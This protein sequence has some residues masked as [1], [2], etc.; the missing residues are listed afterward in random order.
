MP[1]TAWRMAATTLTSAAVKLANESGIVIPKA[2]LH[3]TTKSCPRLESRNLCRAR[4]SA[5]MIVEA[6]NTLSKFSAASFKRAGRCCN[7][8]AT[9]PART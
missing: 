1:K 7:T 4:P 5:T 3:P 8:T 9:T 2:C 6:S